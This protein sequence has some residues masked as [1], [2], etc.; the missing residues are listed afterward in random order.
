MIILNDD[1]IQTRQPKII[2][3]YLKSLQIGFTIGRQDKIDK[4]NRD[5][6][7]KLRTMVQQKASRQN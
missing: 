6:K 1:Y 2:H 4:N 3:S 7:I 5:T